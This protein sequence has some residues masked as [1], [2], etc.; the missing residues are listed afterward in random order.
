MRFNSLPPASGG[1]VAYV[2]QRKCVVTRVFL[3]DGNGF[4]CETF[5]ALSA[6]LDLSL[7]DELGRY[8]A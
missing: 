4:A 8:S 7:I 3:H 2:S 1:Q 5:S 6:A